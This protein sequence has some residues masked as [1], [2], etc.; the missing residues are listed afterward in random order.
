MNE[1]H[2]K[3][4]LPRQNHGH[5][6]IDIWNNNNRSLGINVLY[7][8]V[9]MA[10]FKVNEVYNDALKEHIKKGDVIKFVIGC[11][12]EE[13]IYDNRFEIDCRDISF[14]EFNS[15]MSIVKGMDCISVIINQC[16]HI[17][18]SDWRQNDIQHDNQT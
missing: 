4:T 6:N 13:K 2:F 18:S 8:G 3:V 9:P 16:G 15:K 14:A 1:K 11:N 7:H 10:G 12:Q 5:T 17:W